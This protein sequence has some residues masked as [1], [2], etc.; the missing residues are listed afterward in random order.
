MSSI[1]SFD[2]SR[3]WH[4][5]RSVARNDWSTAFI[6]VILE[7]NLSATSD[8]NTVSW[9]RLLNIY[10]YP[11][12]KKIRGSEFD[13]YR[14]VKYLLGIIGLDDVQEIAFVRYPEFSECFVQIAR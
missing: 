5:A 9:I 13:G 4:N 1:V 2:G 3:L 6:A 12:S 10:V 14:P 11:P 7:N 8:V